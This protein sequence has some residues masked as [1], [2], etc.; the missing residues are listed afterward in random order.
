VLALTVLAL[1]GLDLYT[2]WAASGII[3]QLAAVSRPTVVKRKDASGAVQRA[4]VQR[5]D[6][7]LLYGSSELNADT[8]YRAGVLFSNAPTGFYVLPVGRPGATSL[9]LLQQM[10]ALGTSLRGERVAISVSEPWMMSEMALPDQYAGNFYVQNSS[11]LLFEP[12]LSLDIKRSAAK[13]MLDYPGTLEKD[14]LAYQAAQALVANDLP[15]T[16]LYWALVPLGTVNN[17]VYRL[18]DD[19]ES[20]DLVQQVPEQRIRSD[21]PP[22]TGIADWSALAETA[23]EEYKLEADNNPYGIEAGKWADFNHRLNDHRFLW[24]DKSFKQRMQ[25]T[26]EWRDL[27]LL[28]HALRE[29]GA[30]PLVLSMP[31]PRAYWERLGVSDSAQA[32]YYQKLHEVAAKYGVPVRDFHEFADDPYFMRDPMA[33]LSPEGWVYYDQALDSFYHDTL[34]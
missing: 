11:E 31:M 7:M 12:T 33:H 19:W 23:R 21:S 24:I 29:W 5:P 22:V 27:D 13:R 1:L 10:A 4:A 26:L 9:I 30:E 8:P 18:Q 3:P 20:L 2:H 15:Q 6:V 14:P 16:L 17:L 25:G 28:L 32:V 34:Y